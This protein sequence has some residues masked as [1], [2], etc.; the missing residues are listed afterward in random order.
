MSSLYPED[1]IDQLDEIQ[2]D[3]YIVHI[4]SQAADIESLI[5]ESENNTDELTGLTI[6]D[7]VNEAISQMDRECPYINETVAVTGRLLRAYYDEI[8]QKFDTEHVDVNRTPMVS[9][10]YKVLEFTDELSGTTTTKVGHL[11]LVDHMPP[12]NDTPALVDY[13]PRLFA[14]APAGQVNIEYSP[15]DADNIAYLQKSIPE[16]LDDIDLLISNSDDECEAILGLKH[17]TITKQDDLPAEVLSRL[18]SYVNKRLTFN[19][20]MPYVLT[21]S[22]L[23]YGDEDNEKRVFYNYNTDD[24][25]NLVQIDGISLRTYPD[26]VDGEIKCSEDLYWCLDLIDVSKQ[27]KSPAIAVP[28]ANIL[29]MRSTVEILSDS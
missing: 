25:E 1:L 19:S 8:N 21:I 5:K 28:I 29:N 12:Q 20:R 2:L 18:L 22:G 15:S 3:P 14:F 10:G 26:L 7:L 16:I 11:L 24:G 6:N 27:E 13:I 9:C 23:V 17:H 4:I